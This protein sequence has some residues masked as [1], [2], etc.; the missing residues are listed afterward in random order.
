MLR[1]KQQRQEEILPILKKLKELRL[2]PV[3]SSEIKEFYVKMQT[4]IQDGTRQ[5]ILIPFTTMDVRLV[6]VL[7]PDGN[8]RTWVKL[9]HIKD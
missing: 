7:A 9:E 2:T 1:T 5:E 3:E 8:E 4:Y 6:G